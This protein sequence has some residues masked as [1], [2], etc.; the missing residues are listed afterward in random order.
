MDRLLLSR[1]IDL[2]VIFV[3]LAP[4]P[5]AVLPYSLIFIST[6]PDI[7]KS[8]LRCPLMRL[9][10]F[11]IDISLSS[12]LS[13]TAFFYL[14]PGTGGFILEK[15]RFYSGLPFYPSFI[16]LLKV[17]SFE[18]SLRAGS[19][20]NACFFFCYCLSSSSKRIISCCEAILLFNSPICCYV[21]FIFWRVY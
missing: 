10:L 1:V 14:W 21:A 20:E 9:A 19:R 11:T 2:D 4:A 5:A 15:K 3:R 16:G 12:A 7:F 18:C 6:M 8:L 17:S 13:P